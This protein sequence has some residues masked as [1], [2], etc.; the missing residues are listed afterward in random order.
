[1]TE[2]LG[3]H[4]GVPNLFGLPA[5]FY[6]GTVMAGA[7]SAAPMAAAHARSAHA[8]R[9]DKSGSEAALLYQRLATMRPDLGRKVRFH[10]YRMPWLVPASRAVLNTARWFTQGQI[11]PVI[12]SK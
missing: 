10:W 8:A 4:S 11:A 2:N 9:V 6:A 5:P 7:P 12:H 3:S 1:M